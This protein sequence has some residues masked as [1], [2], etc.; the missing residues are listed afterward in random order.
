LARFLVGVVMHGTVVVGNAVFVAV[1]LVIFS[2]F[3]SALA[4]HSYG[5]VPLVRLLWFSGD[6]FFY[7]SE[8]SEDVSKESKGNY[9]RTYSDYP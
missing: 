5:S 2:V 1:F 4:I 3:V 9:A 8:G 6:T 7:L